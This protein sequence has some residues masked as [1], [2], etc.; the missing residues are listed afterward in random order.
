MKT[1]KLWVVTMLRP[2]FVA[3]IA[4]FP[5]QSRAT[6]AFIAGAPQVH[7]HT[8]KVDGAEVLARALSWAP[9][10]ARSRVVLIRGR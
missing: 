8:V 3:I 4:V 6:P 10:R 9:H 7:H 5:G 1:A 2:I